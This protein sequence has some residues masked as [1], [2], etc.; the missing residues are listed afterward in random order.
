MHIRLTEQELATLVQ[1]V[2]LAANVSSWNQ[3][4][5]STSQVAAFEDLE[6]KI[7]EKASHSGFADWLEFD[8]ESQ[9]LRIK[10]EVEADAFYNDCYEE[11]RNES[12]WE[13][14]VIR[15]ADRDL[16]RAIGHSA[17][18]ALSEDQRRA[19]SKD[20]EK[21][22]WDEFIASGIDHVHVINPPGQG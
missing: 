15:L 3:K 13:E 4:P 6:A 8:E 2:S 18:E 19:R 14:L 17:W 9:R 5:G 1:M 7:L 16:A 11:F 22:Y 12:F 10:P 20:T 21:R